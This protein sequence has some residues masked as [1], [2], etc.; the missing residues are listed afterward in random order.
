[1]TQKN[2]AYGS[3]IND[4]DDSEYRDFVESISV[5]REELAAM[6]GVP[7]A[8]LAQE[9]NSDPDADKKE[10]PSKTNVPV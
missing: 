2:R 1:M 3:N 6:V 4:E 10:S 7:E 5:T 9:L 8:S